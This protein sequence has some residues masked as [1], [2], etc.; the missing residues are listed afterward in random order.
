MARELIRPSRLRPGDRVAIAT[1]S[2]A[3]AHEVPHRFDVGVAQLAT[4]FDLEVVELEHTRARQEELSPQARA[5]D[6]HAAFVDPDIR[7]VVSTIGGDD[8]IRM[9]PHVDHDV[10]AANPTIL[11][12]FSDT[13]V[14]QLACLRAG[15]VSFCGPSVLAGFA[16]NGGMFD[17]ARRGVRE[18]LFEPGPTMWRPNPDGWTTELL[19]WDDPTVAPTRRRLQPTRGWKWLRGDTPVTGRILPFCVEVL[20]WFRGTPW[21]PDLDGALLAI[22]TSEEAISPDALV[23]MLRPLGISGEL[24]GLA[25]LLFG[26]PGGMEVD[27]VLDRPDDEAYDAVLLSLLDEFAPHVPLVTGLDFGHTEPTWTLPIGVEAT[28]HPGRGVIEVAAGVG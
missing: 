21:W 16:E 7:A 13:T 20:D 14:A 5:A 6:L 10:L 17:Y 3:G 25:G 1:L 8:S 2:W 28:L 4:T 11:V 9:L 24:A 12:G 26:R 22:E 27:G 23:R 18:V 15:L 19:D